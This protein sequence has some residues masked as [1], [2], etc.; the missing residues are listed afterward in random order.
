MRGCEMVGRAREL[1]MSEVFSELGLLIGALRSVEVG[2]KWSWV[3]ACGRYPAATGMMTPELGFRVGAG[4]PF[5]RLEA[6][7]GIVISNILF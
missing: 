3:E 7:N 4:L 6:W 1:G 5:R 2:R